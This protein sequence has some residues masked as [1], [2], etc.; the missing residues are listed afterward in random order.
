MLKNEKFLIIPSRFRS[1]M[2]DGPIT[3]VERVQENFGVDMAHDNGQ[4]SQFLTSA[5]D[6]FKHHYLTQ[7]DKSARP[8]QDQI[9]GALGISPSLFSFSFVISF[10][11]Q[12]SILVM[13]FPLASLSLGLT[14]DDVKNVTPNIHNQRQIKSTA[15]MSLMRKA[16]QI[17]ARS[18]KH[19]R[20]FPQSIQRNQFSNFS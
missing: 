9:L 5:K 18:F 10:H 15:E 16:C 2:W 8:I 7:P 11:S 13:S 19:V 12:S 17:T 14:F 3:G 20:L 4:L 1:E 6:R